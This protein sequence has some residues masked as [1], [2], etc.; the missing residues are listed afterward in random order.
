MWQPHKLNNL[1]GYDLLA[2]DGEIGRLKQIYFDDQYWVVR[3]FVAHTGAWLTGKDVLI[4]PSII[5]AVDEK[6]HCLQVELNREQIQNCPPIDTAL[7]ISRHYEQE[8]F[9]Y[10]DLKPYWHGKSLLSSKLT[11]PFPMADGEKPENPYLRSSEKVMGYH[12]QALDGEIGHVEDFILEEPDWT[13]R[14]LEINI[15]VWLF[16]K[17]VLIAPAWIQ[18]VDWIRK[19]VTVDLTRESIESAP[20]Y[21]PSE[22]I[23]R[24]YQVALY[25]HYGK[26]YN[27]K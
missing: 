16:G 8:Y 27:R 13:V 10:Y 1:T 19:V 11:P 24:D 21:D 9:R 22:V 17:K 18:S 6:N 14:Y 5:S 3:Y 4:V 25:G 15:G 2:Q 26:T 7:P 20:A 12:I 23:S